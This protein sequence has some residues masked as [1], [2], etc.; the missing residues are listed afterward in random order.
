MRPNVRPTT[1]ST[2]TRV[3]YSSQSTTSTPM[4]TFA[5]ILAWCTWYTELAHSAHSL[6]SSHTS[7]AQ[8]LSLV[9]NISLGH[10]WAHLLESLLLFYFHLSFP[11]LLLFPSTSCTASCTLSST[12][13][14]P[15]K[16]CATPPTRGPT[17]SPPPS[18]VMSPSSW[19]SVQRA[20]RLFR[21]LLLHNPV[22]GPGHGWRDTRASCS[23]RHVEDKPITANQKACQSVQSSSSVV[24]D[25]AGKPAG[26]RNVDQSVGFGATRNTFSAHSKFSENNPS[27][28]SGR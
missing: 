16:A 25:R 3:T 22:I 4:T 5:Q 11:C 6:M 18:Q 13:W 23:Q 12:T 2:T 9:I 20:Q 26:E 24:F 10:P 21:F 27:W 7:S 14:S 15:W 8:D 17:T 28:A 1:A 19:P